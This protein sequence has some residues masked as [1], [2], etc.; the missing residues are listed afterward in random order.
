MHGA[1]RPV[2]EGRWSKSTLKTPEPRLPLLDAVPDESADQSVFVSD[3]AGDWHPEHHTRALG[4]SE[5]AALSE[6]RARTVVD[7]GLTP[8]R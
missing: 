6:K 8:V 7:L 2:R 4:E 1:S 5:T 3:V